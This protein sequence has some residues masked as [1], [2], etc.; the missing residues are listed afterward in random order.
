MGSFSHLAYDRFM[1]F[2]V[3]PES[4]CYA[5]GLLLLAHVSN[6]L[7]FCLIQL[8]WL[9]YV[10]HQST[11]CPYWTFL[12]SWYL[13]A[14]DPLTCSGSPSYLGLHSHGRTPPLAR[15]P[16]HQFWHAWVRSTAI[17]K[18]SSVAYSVPYQASVSPWSACWRIVSASC[19]SIFLWLG[20]SC[21]N[22]VCTRPEV[23]SD[24][25]SL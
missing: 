19:D 11:W 16:S 14:L 1:K 17:T 8:V 3:V 15:L 25:V 2:S 21:I 4:S 22:S 6:V 23:A 9:D 10:Y 12:L 20:P 24:L 7:I 5:C 13:A 18:I